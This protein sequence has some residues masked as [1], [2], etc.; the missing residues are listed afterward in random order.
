M[1]GTLHAGDQEAEGASAQA[2]TAANHRQHLRITSV[3][4]TKPLTSLLDD[5]R[6]VHFVTCGVKAVPGRRQWRNHQNVGAWVN[7]P[8]G[9]TAVS[10]R[11]GAQA[12]LHATR[13]RRCEVLGTTS[14]GR[15]PTGTAKTIETPD[16]GELCQ[17][18]RSREHPCRSLAQLHHRVE[19]YCWGDG[20]AGKLGDGGTTQHNFAGAAAK[21]NHFS[22]SKPVLNHGSITSWTV[23]PALPTGLSLGSTNGT[24][25]ATRP[26]P[27]HKRTSPSTPTT[28][29]GP[30]RSCSTWGSILRHRVRSST[31]QR[32]TRSQT[33]PRFTCT[34]IHQ[35]NNWKRLHV[36]CGRHQQR[37]NRQLPW[38]IHGTLVGDTIYFSA[39]DGTT[40][41]ELWA[42]DTSNHSTWQV[43]DICSSGSCSSNGLYMEILIGDTLYFSAN[44]GTTGTELWAHDTSNHSTW[45]AAISPASGRVVVIQDHT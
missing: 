19:V 43:A 20:K 29:A 6:V 35:P 5:T 38:T 17:R 4:P 44:D 22:G 31:S 37:F 18:H 36:E 24:L 34:A 25:W 10:E 14:T 13:Q 15:W 39:N 12:C 45:K 33:T 1:T 2:V 3:Q 16:N 8:T 7:L 27:S 9:R 28:R 32:T 21:T 11:N 40:G 41:T 42:H 30:P 26:L 23:H